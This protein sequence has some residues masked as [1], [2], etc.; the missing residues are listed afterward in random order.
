LADASTAKFGAEQDWEIFFGQVA[1]PEAEFVSTLVPS[2]STD[3][4]GV[5]IAGP[6]QPADAVAYAESV[7][8]ISRRLG[9]PVLADGLSPLRNHASLVP[10]LMTAY[11]GILRNEAAAAR[12]KPDRVLCLDGWPTSK[13]LRAWL[14]KC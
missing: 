6:A 10:G 13:V 3:V 12:L 8:A 14:E 9:W 11:A 4:H 2:L 5:I 1:P 7:G